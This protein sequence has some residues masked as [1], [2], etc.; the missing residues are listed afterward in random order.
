MD[1]KNLH[2]HDE[3]CGCGHDHDHDHDHDHEH[4]Q[5]ITLVL[6]DGTEMECPVIDIF[7]IEDKSYIAVLHPKDQTALLYKYNEYEDG[8]VELDHIE[9]D[10]EFEK[11]ADYMNKKFN[12]H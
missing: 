11:V 4:Y 5:T 6:E 2:V 12:Q 10:E 3:N 8:S 7:D 1:D 9:S